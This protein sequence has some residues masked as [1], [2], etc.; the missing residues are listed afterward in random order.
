MS[1]GRG[2]LVAR[3]DRRWTRRLHVLL[4]A[5]T[6]LFTLL[7]V[8]GLVQSA[9][10]AVPGEPR[11]GAGFAGLRLPSAGVPL[12][13]TLV[14]GVHAVDVRVEAS[15]YD[16]ERAPLL[17]GLFLFTW[18]PT[19]L[20]IVVALFLLTRIATRGLAGDRA[21][22]SAD[23]VGDLRRI[24]AVLLIGSPV[25]FALDLGAKTVAAHLTVTDAWVAL[26]DAASPV[27][28]ML[29][30]MGAFVVAEVIGRGLVM[31]DELEGTI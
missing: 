29:M 24:G 26:G 25:A 10:M 7:L 21:L 16:P 18:L 20:I 27:A 15:L 13:G 22:F 9:A 12:G 17:A 2:T 11:N 4:T 28:G 31:L 14:P 3:M 23:T 6:V 5:A 30:G 19:V 1:D 8:G